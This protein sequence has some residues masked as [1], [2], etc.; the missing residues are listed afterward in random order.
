MNRGQTGGAVAGAACANTARDLAFPAM[1]MMWRMKAVTETSCPGT[2]PRGEMG[3][4]ATGNMGHPRGG[5]VL[6]FRGDMPAVALGLL[7]R[8]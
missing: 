3:R 4:L 6:S 7:C 5:S 2:G 8:E 1:V